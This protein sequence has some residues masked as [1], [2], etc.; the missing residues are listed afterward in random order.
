MP[1]GTQTQIKEFLNQK[2]LVM[3]GVSRDPKEFSR[4][5]FKDMQQRGFEM[6]PVNPKMQEMDGLTCYPNIAAVP[7][8]VDGVVVYTSAEV[9]EQIVREC[10]EVG[11]KRV[12]LP[13]PGSDMTVSKDAVAYCKE[14]GIDV[15]AGYCPYMFI[16][17]S[18]FF[19]RM[20]GGFLKLIGKYPKTA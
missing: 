20:H 6:V 9:S 10:V 2:R 5:L 7:A 3:V 1:T 8:P 4:Q 15:I 11:V 12:W 17:D 19:H 14:N 18:P 16:K 13:G